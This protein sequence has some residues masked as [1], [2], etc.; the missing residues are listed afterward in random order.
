M[1]LK[2]YNR[3]YTLNIYINFLCVH[4]FNLLLYYLA[5][6]IRS[7]ILTLKYKRNIYIY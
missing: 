3:V 5:I 6:C 4:A 7:K 2:N 1:V